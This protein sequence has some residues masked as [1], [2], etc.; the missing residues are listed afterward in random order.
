MPRT[1][2]LRKGPRNHIWRRD[3]ARFL[4]RDESI[5]LYWKKSVGMDLSPRRYDNRIWFP[6]WKIVYLKRWLGS[7]HRVRARVIAQR[8][9]KMDARRKARLKN[10]DAEVK[11]N[12][13][14]ITVI[15]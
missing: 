1:I 4:Q 3:A 9:A 8:L 6:V 11:A 5:F 7:R 13:T 14:E 2:T 10:S 15:A 12:E